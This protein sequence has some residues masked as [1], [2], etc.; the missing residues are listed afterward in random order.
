MTTA[1][2]VAD[3]GKKVELPPGQEIVGGKVYLRNQKGGLDPIELVKQQHQLEDALVRSLFTSAE[4]L[5]A[6]IA[7]F[8]LRAYGDV[9]AFLALLEE[10]YKS[11]AGGEKGNLTLAS[12]DGLFRIQVQVSDTLEFGPELQVAKQLLDEVVRNRSKGADPVLVGMVTNAFKTDKAGQISKAAMFALL[13]YE[14]D[15]EDWQAAMTALRDS[16]RTL[17]SRRYIRFH[18]RP[19]VQAAWRHLSLDIANA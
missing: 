17:G 15:D 4:V 8:K 7:A 16:I 5:G 1:D 19:S 6:A 11:K 10:V 14:I 3:A 2:H 18:H 12:Y 13:R 9:D